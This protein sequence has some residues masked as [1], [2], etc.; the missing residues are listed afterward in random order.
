MRNLWEYPFIRSKPVSVR[1]CFHYLQDWCETAP[2]LEEASGLLRTGLRRHPACSPRPINGR[3]KKFKGFVVPFMEDTMRKWCAIA[4]T[5]VSD[6]PAN[7]CAA[8]KTRAQ[9]TAGKAA[10]ST[11]AV[12]ASDFSIVPASP[13][14][15][16]MPAPAAKPADASFRIGPTIPGTATP[17]AS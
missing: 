6:G 13:N 4:A 11:S 3:R 7:L 12:P 1:H 2:N 9:Q 8:K 17:G 14:L 10:E 15:F 5:G 16:A